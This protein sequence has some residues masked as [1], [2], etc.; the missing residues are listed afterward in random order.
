MDLFRAGSGIFKQVPWVFDS[1]PDRTKQR[2]LQRNDCLNDGAPYKNS[3]IAYQETFLT[4]DKI[5][6]GM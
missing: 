4:I 1:I 3:Q 2:L 6:T 5:I